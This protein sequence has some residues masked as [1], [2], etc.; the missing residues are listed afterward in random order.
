MFNEYPYVNLQDVNLDWILKHIKDLEINLQDF[1][2]LNTIKYADPI[3]WNIS[4]QYEANT[5]VVNDFT[6]VAYLSTQ[7]VPSGVDVTNTDY[8][9]PIF[10]LDFVN[11]NKNI[12]LRN[13]GN[14]NNATFTSAVG[15]WLIVGGQLY[16]V[17]QDIA[18]HTAYVVGF[19]LQVYS[20][21][22]FVKDYLNQVLNLIGDLDD[23]TT[24][25]KTS[26]VNAI[27]SV[28]SDINDKIGDLDDLD[29]TDKT[30]IVNAINSA[31]SDINDKIGDLDDLDTT[32]KASIVDAINS[33]LSDINDKIGDLDDLDTTD[34]TS[35]VN[36]INELN[37]NHIFVSPKS[38]GAVGDGVTDDTA[39]VQECI[40]N[41][42]YVIIDG[43][44]YVTS[45]I[46]LH[47]DLYMM[48]TGNFYNPLVTRTLFGN[49]VN[50][51]I[52]EGFG[53]I[54]GARDGSHPDM[55]A[56]I[57]IEGGNNII[58][59]GIKDVSNNKPSTIMLDHVTNFNIANCIIQKSGY[60]GIMLHG[61]CHYGVIQHN[62][63]EVDDYTAYTNTYG[64][65]VSFT[66]TSGSLDDRSNE[67]T[68]V[69]IDSNVVHTKYS[70]WEGIDAHAGQYLEITNNIV[71]G[72]YVGIC[73]TYGNYSSL[74][75][76]TRYSK[77][78]GNTIS[79]EGATLHSGRTYRLGIGF[80]SNAAS[81][82][83]N[84]VISDN[85]ISNI[86]A[87]VGGEDVGMG[88]E[89]RGLGFEI[90][91]NTFQRNIRKAI[92][93]NQGGRALI[94]NN[95]FIGAGV[96]SAIVFNYLTDIVGIFNN[97]ASRYRNFYEIDD[98]TNL[99]SYARRNGNKITSGYWMNDEYGVTSVSAFVPDYCKVSPVG[100]S[101]H[102]L[103]EI[104]WRAETATGQPMGW[105]S[106]GST[107]LAMSNLS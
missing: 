101:Y 99:S 81:G 84:N 9:T 76:G 1:I 68:H 79:A 17:I 85:Y 7:P 64:I 48:G 32:D 73:C 70:F 45:P 94:Q 40:D 56:N 4:K 82:E 10:T 51:I 26:I 97:T 87:S 15:D 86:N 38:Y 96:C 75:M 13:D 35:V 43:N 23:L 90:I 93:I 60:C 28:L 16:K 33:A 78:S 103:D 52:L 37:A 65:A 14:N 67:C 2:K 5:V 66:P 30:S 8:W 95:T 31:L 20:V 39:A 42:N 104:T 34:K 36:A 74:N 19:N 59:D 27:N 24:S 18:L 83:V 105:I 58:I 22:L 62:D 6:G 50:N 89:F 29:T 21:E 102:P 53:F 69:I 71:K 49:N 44:F 91:G 25:D 77:I 72:F 63:V 41:N 12:T 47:S 55:R 46:N 92:R 107:W 54:N 88:I 57:Y 61:N 106:N 98:S 100:S 11:L 3:D 80:Y